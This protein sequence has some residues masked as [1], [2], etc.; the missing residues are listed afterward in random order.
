MRNGR[1]C[2][3]LKPS[4]RHADELTYAPAEPISPRERCTTSEEREANYAE[5]EHKGEAGVRVWRAGNHHAVQGGAAY[6][7]MLIVDNSANEI[8]RQTAARSMAD[9]IVTSALKQG[10]AVRG[11]LLRGDENVLAAQESA[12]RSY[13]KTM[14]E[15]TPQIDSQEGRQLLGKIQQCGNAYISLAE[16]EIELK[17]QKKDHE[18]LELMRTQAVP[19]L[20]ALEEATSEFGTYLQ[21]TTDDLSRR[22]NSDVVA[23]KVFIVGL[24]IAGVILRTFVNVTISRSVSG[25]IERII[26]NIQ[27]L[28][29][30]NLAVED[31]AMRNDEIG[32][33]GMAL[34]EMKNN[35]RSIIQSL[36]EQ[37]LT[38]MQSIADSVRSSAGR[39]REL[40]A[41]SEKI[42]RI[43]GVINDIADQT[44]LLALNAAIEAARAGEQER[45]FAVVADEVRKL[46]ERT[47]IAT[48]EIAQMILNIQEETKLAVNSMDEGTKQVGEGV[49]G[50]EALTEIIQMSEQVGMMVTQIATAATEQSVTT[51]DINHSM[52]QISN[53][54]KESA[55]GAQQSAQAC[56]ELSGMAFELQ[57]IVTNFKL[58]EDGATRPPATPQ[59]RRPQKAFAAAAR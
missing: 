9:G 52:E 10:S 13:E 25:A 20:N 46:A 49:P 43:I 44:N 45:G 33:A 6:R 40:G 51:E 36:V 15:L 35:L 4:P 17:R 11:F 29:A 38:K 14:D 27:E 34:N 37:T 19:A 12:R 55:A 56:Q 23:E 5:H 58:L 2:L 21:K 54:V 47:T 50:R 16:R 26:S 59:T 53:L 48:K 41:S 7:G 57:K 31:L 32:H 18:A 8:E 1:G 39:V 3:L 24:C 28:A 42:G 30:N 22:R